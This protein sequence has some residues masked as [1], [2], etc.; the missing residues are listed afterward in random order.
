MNTD[1]G[2]DL[3]KETLLSSKLSWLSHGM[4][5]AKV[6]IISLITSIFI[7]TL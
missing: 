4:G 5:K 6:T 7:F 3:E 2:N 1:L